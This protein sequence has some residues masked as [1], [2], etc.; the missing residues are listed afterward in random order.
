MGVPPEAVKTQKLEAAPAAEAV[1]TQR[2]DLSMDKLREAKRFLQ[3]VVT[4]KG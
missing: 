2:L 1:K 4:R 3:G